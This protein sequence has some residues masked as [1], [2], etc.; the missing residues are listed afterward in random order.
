MHVKLE[1][2]ERGTTGMDFREIKIKEC[3]VDW[4]RPR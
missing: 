2:N 1:E 3:E 4:Y